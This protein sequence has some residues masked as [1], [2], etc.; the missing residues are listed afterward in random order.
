MNKE[1]VIGREYETK[2]LLRAYD[3]TS[4]QLVIISGR[5][6]VGKTYL[7]NNLFNDKFVF[8]LTGS[9]SENKEIQLN[10][11]SIEL[12]KRSNNDIRKYKSWGEAFHA[13]EDYLNSINSNDKLVVFFDEMPW[14]DNQ[15]S[16]FL[17]AFEYFW[18]SYGYAKDNLM[19]IVCGS[20]TSWISDKILKNK[21]GLFNRYTLQLF[22]KPFTLKE[23]KEFLLSKNIFWSNY[24]IAQTYMIMGGIPFYLMQIDES[25]TLGENIDNMFFKKQGLLWNEF[26]NLYR[27]LFNNN[28]NYIKIVEALANKKSGLSRLEICKATNLAPNG[29]MTK[30]LSDLIDSYFITAMD[31]YK[32][33]KEN[34]YRL[35]DFYTL[36]Y[37][38]FIKNYYSQDEHFWANSFDDPS[39]KVWLGLSFE[40][41]CFLHLDEIKKALGIS[42]VSTK[43]YSYYKLGDK[44]TKGVL[45]DLIIDRKDKVL[46]LV[47]IKYCAGEFE[48]DKQYD[49]NLRNK[50]TALNALTKGKKSIRLVFITTYGVKKNEYSNIV[51][52][53]ILI[54]DLFR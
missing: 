19:F 47:E 40:L 22:L 54:D 32:D 16:G 33:R 25:L 21:G 51:N 36:F 44:S 1:K 23:T 12:A 48:I 5:R 43:V 50:I 15:K 52:K 34:I 35:T 38:K 49:L 18:N 4:S 2:M 8:K 11:F 26:N 9:F 27:T 17:S 45:I 3:S 28:N 53:S 29:M 31:S 41:L 10:N 6:R 24:D 39:R 30:M 14:L 13:L 20:S 37:F 7:V 42:G 46:E